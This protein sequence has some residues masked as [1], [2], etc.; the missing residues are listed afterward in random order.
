M[1]QF[2]LRHD[3]AVLKWA[4]NV[5]STRSVELAGTGERYIAPM[6][7]MMN[8]GADAEVEISYDGMSGDCHAYASVDIPAG[9]RLRA[10]YGGLDTTQLFARYGFLE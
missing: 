8:H 5:A 1:A 2:G 10:S 3:S 9:C 6:I 4:Y 7:D